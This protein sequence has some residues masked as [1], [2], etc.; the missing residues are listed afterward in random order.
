MLH[1]NTKYLCTYITDVE[2]QLKKLDYKTK[3]LEEAATK[4]EKENMK[5]KLENEKEN[6]SNEKY[7]LPI[8]E[9]FGEAIVNIVF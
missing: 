9:H 6:D 3:N 2:E 5:L 7:Y 4:L 8:S 1:W